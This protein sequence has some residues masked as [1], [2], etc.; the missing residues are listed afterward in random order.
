MNH[1]KSNRSPRATAD[2]PG[3][4]ARHKPRR[5]TKG[6]TG[7][8]GSKSPNRWPRAWPAEHPG[9]QTKVRVGKANPGERKI[10][11]GGKATERSGARR[12]HPRARSGPEPAA[13]TRA[14][15][16]RAERGDY[17]SRTRARPATIAQEGWCVLLVPM[18]GCS[19]PFLVRRGGSGGRGKGARAWACPSPKT[20]RV[21][22]RGKR[23]R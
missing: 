23:R 13:A 2:I 7:S 10:G 5:N 15:E 18:C 3:P 21:G 4:R 22:L 19:V 16:S 12:E 20:P 17:L 6:S 9:S 1:G 14:R 11:Q 8:V